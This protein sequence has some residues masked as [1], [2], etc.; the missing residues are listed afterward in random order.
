MRLNDPHYGGFSIFIGN[1]EHVAA[2]ADAR[3]RAEM[4]AEQNREAP[5]I[6]SSERKQ[7]LYRKMLARQ[8]RRGPQS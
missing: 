5:T 1:E 6:Q 2:E 4:I 3:F 8:Q 7:A